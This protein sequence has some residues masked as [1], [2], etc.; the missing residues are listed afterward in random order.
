MA[1]IESLLKKILSAVY[2]KDVRQS[3]HDSIKQCYYDGKA[4]GN[5][6]EARER[7]AAA[8]AR[9]DTFT[10]L[11]NGSTAGDAE[12]Q[13][14]RIGLDG[15]VYGS[16]G[17]AVREQIRDTHVIEVSATKP[18]R[19]NTVMWLNPNERETITIPVI[20][21]GVESTVELAYSAVMVK[22]ASGEYESFPAVK[23][24]SVYEIA[25]R[26]GYV[27]TEDD[28]IKEILSDGWVN[29]CLELENKKANKTDVYTRDQ[30]IS[31]VT[32]LITSIPADELLSD[33]I[34]AL[35][36]TPN[37]EGDLLVK[38][39]TNSGEPVD[40]CVV[41]VGANAIRTNAA[42]YARFQ[43][44]RGEYH[45]DVTSPIDYGAVSQ[46]GSATIMDGLT[47]RI[48]FIIANNISDGS[49][50]L[51]LY[52]SIPYASFS[53][54]VRTADVFGVGGGGSGAAAVHYSSENSVVTVGPSATGG[55]GGNTTLVNGIATNQIFTITVGSG[56]D[57]VGESGDRAGSYPGNDGGETKVVNSVGNIILSAPGGGGG[58][59]QGSTMGPAAGASGGS[60]SGG[61]Y[62]K[63][64]HGEHEASVGQSGEDGAS[65]GA[66]ATAAGGTGQGSTTRMW[67]T[68]SGELFSSAGGSAS[69]DRSYTALK[70]TP[71]QGGGAAFV[72]YSNSSGG[73]FNSNG[74]FE[75]GSATTYGSGGGALAIINQG[76]YIIN[77]Y[78]GA[79]KQGFVAFRWG[80]A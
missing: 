68:T 31:D 29:A 55:A 30:S 43:L 19:D 38:C 73:T 69:V 75:A 24:E 15:T 39:K 11:A 5:D 22:N 61:A 36:T 41:V 65:G 67:H 35:S 78:S 28:F 37:G 50:E 58:K 21:N 80:V 20:T 34:N 18:T 10:K 79:G 14:I 2:G 40:G 8:E 77:Y 72:G 57:R 16:A 63:P 74:S 53:S 45:I 70:G 32:R 3:I 12:L 47:T 62:S 64:Q 9:M 4:G 13:D 44:P 7:A 26:H 6:L 33:V 54:R 59:I 17:S 66:A 27:G 1:D 56:G 49:N 76:K 42:G 52:S 60:G 23:G 48:D 71:G 25:V 46:Q 51:R